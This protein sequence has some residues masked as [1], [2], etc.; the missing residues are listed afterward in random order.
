MVDGEATLLLDGIDV[1]TLTECVEGPVVWP[2][3][4]RTQK[5]D[6]QRYPGIDGGSYLPQ[7]Y[8]IDVLPLT[9]TLRS[10][11]CSGGSGLAMREALRDL[12]TACRPDRQVTLRRLWSDTEYEEARAKFLNITPT[13]AV[14]NVMSCLVEFQLL[15]LWYGPA[16]SGI[17]AAGTHTFDGDTRTHRIQFTLAAGAARTITNTTNG[18]ALTFGGTVPA[19]GVLID[20]E[21]RTARAITGGTNLDVYL[22][23]TKFHPM[24]FDPGENVL[25]VSSGTATISYQPAYL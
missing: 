12:R 10:P 11:A 8:D 3:S 16:V 4:G 1:E 6:L 22:T 25:T 18:F 21:A 13:R 7:P 5:G 17:S 9:V 19:G 23:W 20:V 24:R 2:Y 14:K 15:E